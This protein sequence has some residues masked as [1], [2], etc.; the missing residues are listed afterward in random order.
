M[1]CMELSS[2]SYADIGVPIDLRG[3]LRKSLEVLKEAKPIVLYDGERGI[4]LKPVM[5]NWS[6][7]QVDLGYTEL[8]HIP[9]VTSVSF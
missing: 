3:C 6:S 4:A 7:F 8:F 1:G 5:G 9:A 2:S